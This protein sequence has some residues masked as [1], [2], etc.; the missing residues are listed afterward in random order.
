[1][2]RPVVYLK[3]GGRDEGRWH[4]MDSTGDMRMR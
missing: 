2:P 1:M 4:E 3:I